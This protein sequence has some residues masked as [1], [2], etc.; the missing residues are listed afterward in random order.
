VRAESATPTPDTPP[1]NLC[2]VAPISFQE[3]QAI[4]AT[5]MATPGAAP[6]SPAIPTG[7]PADP[8]TV[9]GITQTVRELIACFN[10]DEVLRAYGLYTP[11]YLRRIFSSQDPL[12]PATYAALATPHLPDAGERSAILAIAD[13]RLF[14]DGTAGANITI[15]YPH[16]PVPKTF[17]FTFV[18]EGDR[19][20]IDGALG[21]ISF[22]VP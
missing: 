4:L 20:L 21:E 5:P 11:D 19:W 16:I 17:F 14:A 3:L 1:P 18:R 8:D 22:S 12:T 7:T 2:R 9:A 13:V 15:R 6:T 10:A